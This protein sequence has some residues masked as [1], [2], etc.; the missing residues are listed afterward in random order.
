MSFFLKNLALH[1]KCNS[2]LL[3]KQQWRNQLGHIAE[4]E[5]VLN[6]IQA[7]NVESVV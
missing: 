4:N 3:K 5:C 2:V 7:K 6:E 1:N